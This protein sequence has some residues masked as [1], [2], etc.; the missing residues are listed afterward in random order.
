MRSDM[1]SL[2]PVYPA[3]L[4]CAYGLWAETQGPVGA[5]EYR[6]RSGEKARILSEAALIRAA[7]LCAPPEWRGTQGIGVA[8]ADSGCPSLWSESEDQSK[9]QAVISI[10]E[11]IPM[12]DYAATHLIRPS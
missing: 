12:S 3:M 8:D 5:A 11:I 4:G 9:P 1:A 10:E 2:A 7:E 6:S